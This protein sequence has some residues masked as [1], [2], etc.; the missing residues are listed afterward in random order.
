M[1]QDYKAIEFCHKV[2][3]LNHKS[4]TYWLWAEIIWTKMVMGRNGHGPKWLRAKMTS[5]HT[6]YWLT[7]KVKS[8]K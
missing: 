2:L 1:R 4:L 5:N 7:A 8:N 3:L 6:E